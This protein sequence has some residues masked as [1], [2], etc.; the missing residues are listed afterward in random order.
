MGTLSNGLYYPGDFV[1]RPEDDPRRNPEPGPLGLIGTGLMSI[2]AL[3]R[4]RRG[5][6]AASVFEPTSCDHFPTA[7]MT[8]DARRRKTTVGRERTIVYMQRVARF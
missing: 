3:R 8:C 2:V 7:L 1:R 5:E 4:K 6:T